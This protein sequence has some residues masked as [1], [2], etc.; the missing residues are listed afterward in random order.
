MKTIKSLENRGIFLKETSRKIARQE[1]E[2][3][4]FLRPLRL[5]GLQLMKN[6]LTPLAKSVLVSLGL[7]EAASATDAAVQKKFFGSGMT[8]LTISSEKMEDIMKI[9]KSL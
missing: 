9:V 5:V 8:L 3:F 7:A 1:G 4:N 2:L 6:V